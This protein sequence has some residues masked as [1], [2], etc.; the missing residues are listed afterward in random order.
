MWQ[1]VF[2]DAG[3]LT[4]KDSLLSGKSDFPKAG[5]SILV[6]QW[7]PLLAMLGS[8]RSVS[9]Q[10]WPWGVSLPGASPLNSLVQRVPHLKLI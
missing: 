4:L 1:L 8:Y 2:S 7:L 10:W 3:W 9:I 6:W 5:L